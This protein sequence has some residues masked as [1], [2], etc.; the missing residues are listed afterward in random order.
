MLIWVRDGEDGGAIEKPPEAA[1]HERLSP[2]EREQL[3]T[4]MA[5]ISPR[6]SL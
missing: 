1:Q 4:I 3:A 2:E 6:A 5:K